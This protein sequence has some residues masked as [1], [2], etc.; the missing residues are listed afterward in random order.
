VSECG[1]AGVVGR[2]AAPSAPRFQRRQVG[3]H[4]ARPGCLF[5]PLD[6]GGGH[7]SAMSSAMSSACSYH[8]KQMLMET[9]SC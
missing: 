7:R 2:R 5:R 8:G 6:A 4:S 9:S 3:S 1:F